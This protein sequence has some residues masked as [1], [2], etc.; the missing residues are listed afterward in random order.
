MKKDPIFIE[1]EKHLAEVESI[2][3]SLIA[4]YEQQAAD[5]K[6]DGEKFIGW[7]WGNHTA[8]YEEQHAYSSAKTK[9]EEYKSYKPEPYFGRID[10]EWKSSKGYEVLTVY[11]GHNSIANGIELLAVDWRTPIGSCYYSKSQTEF[12]VEDEF[13]RLMLRRSLEIKRSR[14]MDCHTDYDA[15]T[16]S[17]KGD[18]IDPFLLTV[19]KD[20]RRQ[21]RMTNIIRSIQENQNMIIRRPRNESFVVQGCAGSGK[22]MILLHR[23]SYLMFNNKSMNLFKVSLHL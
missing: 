5:A 8:I 3:D 19:L 23:L 16:I 1:E 12:E 2:L 15:M 18:V 6:G 11:V 21:Y 17:L 13:Y 20:K 10:L 14:L 9:V 4:K 7:N 22:T